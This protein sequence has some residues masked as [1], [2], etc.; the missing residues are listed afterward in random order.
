[1][2]KALDLGIVKGACLDVLE[3][4]SFS[5]ETINQ[6]QILEQKVEERTFEIEQQNQEILTQNE[7]LYQQQEEILAQ[8]D[9]IELKNKE[10]NIRDK[11]ITSSINSA[12]TIQQA[13]LPNEAIFRELFNDFFIIYRPKDV[14]S[15]DFF[16]MD[17]KDNHIILA[18]I[19]C[20]GHGV[21]GAF[22]SLIGSNLLDRIV[23]IKNVRDPHLIL[24]DLNDEVQSVLKQKET[25]NNNGMD[26]VIISLER[27]A[28]NL[29]KL[30]YSGAKLP[31]FLIKAGQNEVEILKPDRKSI[32]GI[33]NNEKVF[34]NQELILEEGS[35]LYL[36]SDGI[37]DQ[38]N[39]KRAKFGTKRLLHFFEKHKE[40][41]LDFQKIILEEE[42]WTH[43]Q[44]TEQRDDILMIG[45][46]V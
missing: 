43:M 7:E 25:G 23:K 5:F 26:V 37:A 32:G 24:H 11:Q 44:G 4:E 33:Q 22:M 13:S 14:V 42:L 35:L 28:N 15:G 2:L 46:R 36:G 10:L 31:L 38:N 20:T 45:I 39:T 16:W 8:R 30:T 6:N 41:R 17:K 18:A 21:P 9:A 34:T 12:L 27:Y 40:Q 1:M 19:D 29:T 3:T